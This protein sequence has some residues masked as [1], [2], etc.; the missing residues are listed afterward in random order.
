M[1]VMGGYPPLPLVRVTALC[2]SPQQLIE[3]IVNMRKRFAGTY[4]LVVV[5]PSPN[6]LVQLL[7]QDFL[8]PCFPASKDGFRQGRFQRFQRFLGW[9]DNEFSLELAECPSK[10]I[11]AFVNVGND[12]FF[13]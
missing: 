12:R 8:F 7:N 13:L 9:F 3:N 4:G 5:C 11:K 6:L 10:H 1:P 2:P